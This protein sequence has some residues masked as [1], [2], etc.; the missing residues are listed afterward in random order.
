MVGITAASA[1]ANSWPTDEK[2]SVISSR[3]RKS[4]CNPGT[5]AASG[6]SATAPARP[7][8]DHIMICLRLTRSA[9][10]PDGGARHTDGTVTIQGYK[11][12]GVIAHEFLSG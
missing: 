9:I 6:I 8:F 4:F 5:S 2:I 3:C 1:G 12:P 10:P 7:K 11:D